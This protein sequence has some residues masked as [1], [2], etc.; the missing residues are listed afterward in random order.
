M[1][2]ESHLMAQSLYLE[3]NK[4]DTILWAINIQLPP[5]PHLLFSPSNQLSRPV[6]L[7]VSKLPSLRHCNLEC[8]SCAVKPEIFFCCFLN[9]YQ[10]SSLLIKGLY[11]RSKAKMTF[12][13]L[14][15]SFYSL[16]KKLTD[17]S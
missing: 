13:D 1:V 8:K 3:E 6:F 10:N 4:W 9:F 15:F 7:H 2:L 11:P 5:L 16:S 14:S 17:V 12:S